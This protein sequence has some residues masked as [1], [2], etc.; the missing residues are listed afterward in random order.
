MKQI[1]VFKEHRCDV[2]MDWSTTE[3]QQRTALSV[4]KGRF[5]GGN[6]YY[7]ME[8]PVQPN[9]LDFTVDDIEKMPQSMKTVALNR[10]NNHFADMAD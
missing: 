3:I 8:E 6:D 1:I 10:R 5:N 7:Q 4:I 2:A 9:D